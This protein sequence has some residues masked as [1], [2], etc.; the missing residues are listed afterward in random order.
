M[1]R[2]VSALARSSHPGPTAAVTVVGVVLAVAVGLPLDRLVLFGLALIANQLSI[3]WSND[4]L[5]AAK[6]HAVGRT[7]KPIAAGE[8]S[9]SLVRT[10]AVVALVASVA[11]TIPL[12]WAATLAQV[13]FLACGWGY[14]LGLKSTPLS[15]AAYAIGFG[16]LPL[17]ASLALPDPALAAGWAVGAAALLGSAAHFANVLPDLEQDRATSVRGLP[18]LIGSRWSAVII[19]ASLLAAAALVLWGPG[20][21]DPVRAVGAALVALLAIAGTVLALTATSKR[22]L[23]PMIL[24]AVVVLVALLAVSG[25]RLLA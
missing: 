1:L 19:G 5:D 16:M 12:G 22:L 14:N 18:H 7:D 8:V 10:A 4:W 13:V 3:G 6:D 11:L 9:V 17:I 24:G 20:A 23:F 25:S 21:V 2:T 15:V